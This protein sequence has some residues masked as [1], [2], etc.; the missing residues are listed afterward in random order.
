M[1]CLKIVMKVGLGTNGKGCEKEECM[2]KGTTK[3]VEA[4]NPVKKAYLCLSLDVREKPT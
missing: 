4:A 2:E 3:Q 1:T